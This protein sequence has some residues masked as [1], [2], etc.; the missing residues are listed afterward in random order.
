MASLHLKLVTPDRVLLDQEAIS[1]SAPTP[2]GEITVL[3]HHIPLASLLTPGVLRVRRSPQEEDEIAVSGGFIEVK[4]D[5]TVLILADSAERGQELDIDMIEEAKARAKAVMTNAA[6]QDDE[7]FA[8]A[9][10]ALER[11]LARYRVATRH[12]GKGARTMPGQDHV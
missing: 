7:S 6:R 4:R 2:D 8:A 5:G 3:A 9:A 10:A 1:I 11:E 12:R